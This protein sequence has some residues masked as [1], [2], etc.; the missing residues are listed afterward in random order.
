MRE[1]KMKVVLSKHKGKV[2]PNMI[3]TSDDLQPELQD[4]LDSMNMD[5]DCCRMII[6]TS[7]DFTEYY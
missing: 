3:S 7:A 5:R 1:E 2:M 6:L 4:V